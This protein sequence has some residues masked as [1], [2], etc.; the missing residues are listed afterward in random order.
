MKD[1]HVIRANELGQ[2]SF[3]ALAWWLTNVEGVPSANVRELEAGTSAHERHG[4]TVQASTWASRAGMVCLAV[5]VALL[6]LSFVL[7]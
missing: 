3:C 4:R 2:Y 6:A 5:G 1:N 7:R